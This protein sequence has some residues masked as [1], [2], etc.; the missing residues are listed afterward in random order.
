MSRQFA[1]ICAGR[2]RRRVVGVPIRRVCTR[3]RPPRTGGSAGPLASHPAGSP[4]CVPTGAAPSTRRVTPRPSTS[5]HAWRKEYTITRLLSRVRISRE[6]RER[7]MSGISS[8]R[9]ISAGQ[10]PYRLLLP[11]IP[12][13]AA[14]IEQ[15]RGTRHQSASLGVTIRG[16]SIFPGRCVIARPDP[17][18][19]LFP[20]FS[21]PEFPVGPPP[22][23]RITT[24]CTRASHRTDQLRQSDPW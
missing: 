8:R 4:S 19:P 17:T 23:F 9:S 10:A 21:A 2:R 13:I 5:T 24:P 3:W 12:V 20:E 18:F 6:H 11:H 22:I 1:L 15:R 16:A 14:S 7:R